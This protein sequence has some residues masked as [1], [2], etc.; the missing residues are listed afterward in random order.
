M[1]TSLPQPN[2]GTTS[3]VKGKSALR[4]WDPKTAKMKGEGK[5]HAR[6]KQGTI[7]QNFWAVTGSNK[8]KLYVLIYKP[9]LK[10]R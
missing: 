10:C 8:N 4:C 9:Y 5:A 2:P 7:K 6:A 3:V 1:A